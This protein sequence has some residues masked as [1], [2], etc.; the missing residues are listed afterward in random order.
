M[1]IRIVITGRSYDQHQ[2]LPEELECGDEATTREAVARVQALVETPL[3]STCLVAL[4]GRHLGTIG[5]F[6]QTE[7]LPD[8][9]LVFIQPVA[10]G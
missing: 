1:K 7:L 6:E 10:G 8:S 2:A 5:Q 4:N 3:P 9:E